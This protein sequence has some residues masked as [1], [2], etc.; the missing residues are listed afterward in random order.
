MKT[1]VENGEGF[2]PSRIHESH[3]ALGANPG[4]HGIRWEDQSQAL[5]V[6]A[7]GDDDMGCFRKSWVKSPQ[8]IPC[9]IGFSII[10]T[11]PFWGKHPYFGKHPYEG[12]HYAAIHQVQRWIICF[13]SF[14]SSHL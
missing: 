13:F 6:M 3:P 11:I 12:C 2:C 14:A 8:I 9:L 10:L 1:H 4:L 7:I 5:P